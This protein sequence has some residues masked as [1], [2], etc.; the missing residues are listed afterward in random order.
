[1]ILLLLRACWD[2]SFISIYLLPLILSL[3]NVDQF[4]YFPL[5]LAFLFI[6][7]FLFSFSKLSIQFGQWS[8]YGRARGAWDLIAM[9]IVWTWLCWSVD[10]SNDWLV[11][12]WLNWELWACYYIN[13]FDLMGSNFFS[14]VVHRRES[15][16][17]IVVGWLWILFICVGLMV[18]WRLQTVKAFS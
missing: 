9:H 16:T 17:P 14:R 6:K 13:Y 5:A 10:P 1:M 4:E 18:I 11:C 7:W 3:L 15:V 8:R 12:S 2:P